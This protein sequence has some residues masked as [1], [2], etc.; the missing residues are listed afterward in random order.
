[1]HKKVGTTNNFL[2]WIS[3]AL[4]QQSTLGASRHIHFSKAAVSKNKTP[5]TP[6]DPS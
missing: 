1:M 2:S 4:F 5:L 6:L 3:P